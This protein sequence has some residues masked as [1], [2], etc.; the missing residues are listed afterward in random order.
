MVMI[1]RCL[2]IF[3]LAIALLIFNVQQVKA[4]FFD[5]FSVGY[6]GRDE[7]FSLSLGLGV[8]K[9]FGVEFSVI[10]SF[11]WGRV[12]NGYKLKPKYGVD[13]LVSMDLTKNIR[14]FGGAGIYWQMRERVISSSSSD[15]LW[16]KSDGGY[17]GG[18]QFKSDKGMLGLAYHQIRGFIIQ[19]ASYDK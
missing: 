7:A 15:L 5:F 2:I 3:I 10:D 8:R 19:F 11:R 1:R 18:I 9:H 17:S 16:Y 12:V 14:I 13:A 6:G 4:D